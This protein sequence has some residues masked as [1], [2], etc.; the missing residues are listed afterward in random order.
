[1]KRPLQPRTEGKL[2]ESV[3][4]SITNGN[5]PGFELTSHGK[6]WS[7][8]LPSSLS[9]SPTSYPDPAKTQLESYSEICEDITVEATD[10]YLK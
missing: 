5:F 1:M 3:S 9:P 2:H 7:L 6:S 10:E 4:A 8:S